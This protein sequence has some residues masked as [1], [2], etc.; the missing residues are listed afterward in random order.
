M[1][2]KEAQETLGAMLDGEGG[3]IYQAAREHV[4]KCQLC[5][6][7]SE[8]YRDIGANLRAVA[9]QTMPP[10]F[11]G[12]VLARLAADQR[13][14]RDRSWPRPRLWMAQAAALV[15]VT[16]L[17]SLVSW[18]LGERRARHNML[19]RDVVSAHARSL[20]QES[21]VQIASSQSHTVKPWFNGRIE[22]APSVKDLMDRGFPLI[23]GR[24]DF[25]GGQR[26]ATLVYKR[27]LHVINVFIW[28]TAAD[29]NAVPVPT[30]VQGY[31]AISWTAGGLTYWTIS[32]LN[33]RELAELQAL[34]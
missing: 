22:F 30:T 21:P 4:A 23:G 10:R 13:A 7:R 27:R 17:S 9:Y 12:K 18:Q 20:L 2:C 28:P 29:A 6:R 25:V 19:E 1:Q 16:G 11:Q 15:V 24:V 32:D 14:D 34:L 5:A 3:A 8:E 26:A 33:A 31:N